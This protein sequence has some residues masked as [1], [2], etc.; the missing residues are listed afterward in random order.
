MGVKS[1]VEFVSNIALFVPLSLLGSLLWQR[2]TWVAW[3]MAGF[4]SSLVIETT[5]TLLSGRSPTLLDVVA[6]TLGALVGALLV[7]PVWSRTRAR[8]R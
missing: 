3:T 5:Q 8:T 6:N 1:A 4:A 7:L 2:W